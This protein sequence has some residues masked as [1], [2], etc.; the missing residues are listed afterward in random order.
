ML[1]SLG[2]S[3]FLRKAAK[4]TVIVNGRALEAKKGET[5]LQLCDRNNLKIPRL[6]YHPCLPPQGSCG[7]CA[8]QITDAKGERLGNA[9]VT[10]CSNG[11]RIET[12]SQRAIH[13]VKDKLQKL[14]DVHDQQCTSCI[15]YERCE[16]RDLV[17]GNGVSNIDRA[18]PIP[19]SIDIS[20]NSIRIDPSKCVA[21][22]RCVRACKNI[23]GQKVLKVAKKNG[24][25]YVQT[26]NGQLLNDTNCISC[27]QCALYCP[28]GAITEKS[29]VQ[30]ILTRI[31]N[32]T[33]KLS[34]IHFSPAVKIGLADAFGVPISSLPTGKIINALRLYG[35]QQVYDSSFG[36]DIAILEEAARLAAKIQDSND[37]EPLFSSS[38]SAW[39]KYVEQSRSDLIPKLSTVRS[40]TAIMSSLVKN[41]ISKANKLSEDEVCCVSLTPCIGKKNEALRSQLS[42]PKG[43]S[44]TDFSLTIRELVHMLQISGIHILDLPS[45][46][47]FDTLYGASSGSGKLAEISGGQ[48]NGL[49]RTT[50]EIINGKEMPKLEI[51][52][53]TSFK[54]GIKVVEVDMG[55]KKIKVASVQGMANIMKFLEKYKK[56]DKSLDGIKY[57]EMMSCP[58]GCV[59]GGGSIKPTSKANLEQ[60]YNEILKMD[61]SDKVKSPL[62]NELVSKLYSE[63]LGKPES[64]LAKQLLHTHFTHRAGF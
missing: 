63:V 61:K 7:L 43:F 19:N 31:R 34:V 49:L 50:Y 36:G 11:M 59:C 12:H 28:V 20:S 55:V 5:I 60:R 29:Q 1:T 2:S 41:V 53:L 48:L 35:F 39:V 62:K 14:L 30:E 3:S 64:E 47:K 40:P 58:G 26:T 23:S 51:P 27:G 4:I 13:N 57:V 6:C 38:C 18:Y 45:E 37:K 16:F 42:T 56:K 54:D 17:F 25:E 32:R 44:E 24:R 15:A 9:C 21:C 46:G 10:K 52:K 33:K 8:V 22:G